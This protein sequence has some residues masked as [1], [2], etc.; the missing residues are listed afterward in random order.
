VQER[1]KFWGVIAAAVACALT[2]AVLA[3]GYQFG[4]A[5]PGDVREV[6]AAP[7]ASIMKALVEG[8]MNRQPVAWA[9]FGTGAA[10]A[11]VLEMLE[12]PALTFAL[13]MYL[14]LELNSPA[15]VGGFLHH[16]VTR[17]GARARERGVVI[18]S[19]LMAGGALGGVFGAGIKIWNPQVEE[20]VRVGWF[21]VDWLSQGSAILL[22]TGICVYLWLGANRSDATA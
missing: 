9:L 18:A 5:T 14:P 19:G 20:A 13:G 21:D 12:V 7:Q 3:K 11:I 22:F 16:F 8:F 4:Q 15:L 17:R 2:I 1:V 10:I 6:L